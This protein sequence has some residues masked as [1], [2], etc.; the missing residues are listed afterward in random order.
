MPEL[1]HE[2][3]RRKIIIRVDSK[4]TNNCMDACLLHNGREAWQ[5]NTDIH[6]I[7]IHAHFS[8]TNDYLLSSW[9]F[10]TGGKTIQKVTFQ[11]GNI[12]KNCFVYFGQ[13]RERLVVVL[14]AN[15]LIRKLF[16]TVERSPCRM[17]DNR[18]YFSY[19]LFYF[20]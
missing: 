11:L 14:D 5:T 3:E 4:H 19:F 9:L 6:P 12:M 2:N 1:D 17:A 10:T 7:R 8:R 13:Y 20:C 15:I 18:I 16:F